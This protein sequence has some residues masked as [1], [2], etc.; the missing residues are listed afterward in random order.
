MLAGGA[1]P[2][3]GIPNITAPAPVRDSSHRRLKSCGQTTKI[4]SG[5]KS[6]VGRNLRPVCV[7]PKGETTPT[8][9]AKFQIERI[10]AFGEPVVGRG[11]K[12][13]GFVA[14]ALIA[15]EPRHAHRGA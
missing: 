2:R 11:E 1:V 8:R 5:S 7:A 15:G 9:R 13:G 12:V 3:L 10:E 4:W 14:P 6:K